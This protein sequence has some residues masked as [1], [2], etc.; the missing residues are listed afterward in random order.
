[1]IVDAGI[2]H[3]FAVFDAC[4]KADAAGFGAIGEAAV[5][6][7]RP[8]GAAV[9]TFP[10]TGMRACAVEIPGFACALPDG[11]VQDIR[12]LWIGHEINGA[13]RFVAEEAA[14]PGFTAVGGFEHAAFGVIGVE[15]AEYGDPEDVGIGGV[16]HDAPDVV[17]F[18]Q[19]ALLPGFA[20]VGAAVD[21]R[22]GVGGAAAVHFARTDPDDIALPVDG[23]IADGH[24]G[25]VVEDRFKRRAITFGVPEA[26]RGVGDVEFAGIGGIDVYIRDAAGEHRGADALRAECLCNGVGFELGTLGKTLQ[27]RVGAGLGC[28]GQGKEEQ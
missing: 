20:A 4:G 13:G 21:A 22:A 5:A 11:G 16:Q 2:Q 15:V 27:A 6:E 28:K 12:V 26:A 25:F 10:D 14:L 3:R 17:A 19:A 9:G 7:S 18:G 1:M 8:V 23:D 24:G